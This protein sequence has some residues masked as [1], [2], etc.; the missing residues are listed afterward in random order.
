MAFQGCL[1]GDFGCH[2]REIEIRSA[3]VPSQVSYEEGESA[4]GCES[5]YVN[6]SSR[7]G[8]ILDFMCGWIRPRCY[9]PLRVN[10]KAVHRP[11]FNLLS[12][13]HEETMC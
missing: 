9:I 5:V 7:V 13:G 3:A 4:R 12:A 1:G 8:V 11:E 2:N 10:L 6:K